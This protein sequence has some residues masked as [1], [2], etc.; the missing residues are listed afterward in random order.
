MPE[1]LP[2]AR[3]VSHE[4]LLPPLLL[5]L[6]LQVSLRNQEGERSVENKALSLH[7]GK[8]SLLESSSM[9]LND[10]ETWKQETCLILDK[11]VGFSRAYP[12]N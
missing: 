9:S 2:V 5:L 7:R 6:A 3:K 12:V 8:L 11:S 1:G 4:E 10:C